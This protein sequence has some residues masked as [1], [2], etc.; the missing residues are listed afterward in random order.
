M[1]IFVTGDNFFAK[2]IVVNGNRF[3]WFQKRGKQTTEFRPI[4]PI[5]KIDHIIYIK[6]RA[7]NGLETFLPYLIRVRGNEKKPRNFVRRLN[8]IFTPQNAST[9][10]V[11]QF[12]DLVAPEYEAII[13]PSI[14][15][16]VYRHL[17]AHIQDKLA[18]KANSLKILDYGIGTG[19]VLDAVTF[20]KFPVELYGA[21]LSQRMLDIC[22]RR[23]GSER[24]KQIANCTYSK[25][26]FLANFFDA[27]VAC[28]V[29][30]YFIDEAPFREMWRVLRPGGILAFNLHKP[31]PNY[32]QCIRTTLSEEA[33]RFSGVKVETLPIKGKKEKEV[34]RSIPIVFAHKPLAWLQMPDLHNILHGP[35]REERGMK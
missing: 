24:I 14:N 22:R 11:M 13:D 16:W 3:V 28:F 20:D 29:V 4:D 27:V 7:E 9:D 31:E 21:D 34:A 35:A 12:F 18:N 23:K 1:R 19:L 6:A 15:Q 10:E 30:H 17:F 25:V 33:P 26:P 8:G 5:G 32:E 2:E